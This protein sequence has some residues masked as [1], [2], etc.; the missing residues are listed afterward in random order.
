MKTMIYWG[1]ATFFGLSLVHGVSAQDLVINNARIIVGNGDV[2]DRGSLEIRRGRISSVSQEEAV[3]SDL[4]VLDAQGLTVMPGYIDAHRQVIQDEPDTW[5]AAA[6]DRMQEYLEAGFTTILSSGDPVEPV[7]DLRDRLDSRQIRGP[8]LLVSG[9]VELVGEDQETI[10][11]EAAREAVRELTFTGADA[12]ESVVQASPDSLEEQ[13]LAVIKDEADLQGL[14]TIAHIESVDDAIAAVEGRGGYLSHTPHIGELDQETAQTIVETGRSNAEYGL[15][16]TS[17]LGV[18]IPTF[19]DRNAFARAI[20]GGNGDTPSS[21][22][23]PYPRPIRSNPLSS[24]LQPYSMADLS[25]AATGV[26]NARR[27]RDAGIIY[28]F[29]TDSSFPPIEALRHELIPLKL[30]F[31]NEEIVDTLTRSAAFAV[32]RDDALGTLELGKIA[33]VVILDGDPLSDLEHLFN[34]V[35][36]IRTGQ[37]VV[38]NR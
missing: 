32:R 13:A 10:P 5:M 20:V 38:D 37:I 23:V 11:E 19:S 16:M 17:T 36:V 2:I 15:V 35:V 9:P 3:D 22:A 14:M 30:V 28:G 27:L 21:T 34:V 7:L 4:P 33:D 1:L 25:S 6:A 18:S 26:I 8:R 29:G 12:I 24:D 31:S